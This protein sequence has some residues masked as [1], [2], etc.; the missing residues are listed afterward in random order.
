MSS[1]VLSASAA[2]G[3]VVAASS[4]ALLAGSALA[5]FP[6]DPSVN[7]PVAMKPGSQTVEKAATAA[8]GTTWVGWFDNDGSGFK[9]FVQRLTPEGDKV[10]A[11]EGLL[12]SDAAQS[13]SLVDWDLIVDA[14]GGCVLV[15]TDTR[16]GSDR[17]VI[18]QRVASDGTMLWGDDG[19][20]ISTNDDFE[21]APRVSQD[22]A[23]G[24]FHVSWLR[25]DSARGIYYQRLDGAG[26]EQVT[27]GGV[28]IAGDGT[29]GPGFH[30]VVAHPAGGFTMVYVR[31]TRTFLSPRHVYAQRFD[32]AAAAL[33]NAGNP[34]VISDAASI[35]IAQYPLIAL[36][37]DGGAAF[38]WSDGRDG[39]SDVYAQRVDAS[40]VIQYAADGVSASLRA[41]RQQFEAAIAF[42]D[43]TT[44]LLCFFNDRNGAQS[45]RGI[46]VQRFGAA[47]A[48]ALGDD[49]VEVLPFNDENKGAPRAIPV[50]GGAMMGV[51][52][53]PNSSMGNFDDVLVAVRVDASG[54]PIWA[55]NGGVAVASD[56]PGGKSRLIMTVDGADA[57]RFVWEDSRNDQG[58]IYAQNVNADGSLG[59]A[60]ACEGDT[61][62]D[63]IVNFTDLNAVLSAFGQTGAPGFTGAD[64]NGD[65]V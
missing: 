2:L 16:D 44:D 59:A 4:L 7:L 32:S 31:D 25:S 55:A 6:D 57:A 12:A 54:A 19:V 20:Q 42:V 39:D 17:D 65:G 43:D 58:D 52:V 62:G 14:D 33:W 45:I 41:G 49:A 15:F 1:V 35:P 34:V 11:D 13:T 50:S 56:A 63:N 48:R 3:R 5:A 47:G 18:A 40:G 26:A 36:A 28:R 60:A 23:T 30:T 51:T 29:E 9:V 38:A 24:E 27:S 37:P 53:E 22:A 8:D 21:A 10:F 61:N 46:G 64:V